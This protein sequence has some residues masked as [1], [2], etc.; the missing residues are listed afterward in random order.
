MLPIAYLPVLFI[1]NNRAHLIIRPLNKLH[2]ASAIG[3]FPGF[4]LRVQRLLN[5]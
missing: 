1:L 5:T 4:S 2:A 3:N